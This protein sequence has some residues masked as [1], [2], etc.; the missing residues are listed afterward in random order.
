MEVVRVI[1]HTAAMLLYPEAQLA[2]VGEVPGATET[3][4]RASVTIAAVVMGV[5]GCALAVGVG[6]LAAGVQRTQRLRLGVVVGFYTYYVLRMVA[7]FLPADPIVPPWAV[8]VEGVLSILVGVGAIV[9]LV[10]TL[11]SPSKDGTDS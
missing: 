3:M 6:V 7:V 5:L 10:A 4:L 9:A 8:Y 1:V 11:R 2:A